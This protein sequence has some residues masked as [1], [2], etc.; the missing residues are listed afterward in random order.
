M[1]GL[2]SSM[3]V[4]IAGICVSSCDWGAKLCGTLLLINGIH[5]LHKKR[6]SYNRR[7]NLVITL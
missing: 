4:L 5:V 3:A 2:N 1:Y 6:K 7:I